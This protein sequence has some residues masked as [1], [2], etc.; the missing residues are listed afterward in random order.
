MSKKTFYLNLKNK[1]FNLLKAIN[2]QHNFKSLVK[3]MY[4]ENELYM[5]KAFKEHKLITQIIDT[6]SE[7]FASTEFF[8]KKAILENEIGTF[9]TTKFFILKHK[10]VSRIKI[11]VP[12]MYT[13]TN[14]D[15]INRL[16][17]TLQ[18][19][20]NRQ[21]VNKQSKPLIISDILKKNTQKT[22]HSIEELKYFL[23][24]QKNK[25][26]FRLKNKEIAKGQKPKSINRPAI[27]IKPIRA[28]FRVYCGGLFGTLPKKDYKN[29]LK[30]AIKNKKKT[31]LRKIFTLD[32]TKTKIN[33]KFLPPIRL[34]ITLKKL[35][36]LPPIK[37][38]NFKKVKRRFFKKTRK[39]RNVQHKKAKV[40]NILFKHPVN[41]R[42]AKA[43]IK[44]LGLKE[45]KHK[46]LLKIYNE[47]INSKKK[48]NRSN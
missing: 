25:L 22:P 45:L 13:N 7:I 21:K 41:N 26:Y 15:V 48:T 32:R 29:A 16:K 28:G 35:M 2:T 11:N 24:K 10:R 46:K 17:N 37:K 12:S 5:I 8:K 36:F 23:K 44:I 20:S 27:I 4:Q 39:I 40:I 18:S 14:T 33:K 6:N 9:L 43:K 38:R 42:K 3:N 34:N 30:E 47:I 31:K 1:K 19:F